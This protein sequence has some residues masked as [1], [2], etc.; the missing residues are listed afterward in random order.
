MKSFILFIALA[1]T[2]I[3]YSQTQ[4]TNQLITWEGKAAVGSYAP[5]GTLE[6]LDASVKV[7]EGEITALSIV[8]DMRTLEQENTQL[9]DHLKREDF[10]YIEKFPVA[11]FVLKEILDK[12]GPN[13]ILAGEM[14]IRG[15]TVKENI[16][17]TVEMLE[18][19]L[20]LT[21]AHIMD[22]TDYGIVYNSPSVFKRLKDNAIADEFK[23]IGNL[24][25][26][27]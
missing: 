12:N 17:A 21:F 13:M 14:T 23:L 27:Y 11:T 9:R 6:I 20:S 19:K 2:T 18:G 4:N 22:R 16:P 8:V 7:L 26:D 3:S 10:F 1:I 15:V 5:E 24:T 25:I